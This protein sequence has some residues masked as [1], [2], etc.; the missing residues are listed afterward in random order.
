M[1][2]SE[3]HFQYYNNFKK[4]PEFQ[5]PIADTMSLIGACFMLT[6]ER[7][8]KLNICDKD[9]GSWGSQ[10]IEV[11]VKS[12]T[13]GGKVMVNKNTWFAHCFRTQKGFGFPYPQSNTQVQ[14]AKQKA[15]ELFF[16]NKWEGQIYPLSYMVNK[17][18]PLPGW[19]EK[20]LEQ[21]HT[22]ELKTERSGIYSIT[23]KSNG[24]IYI[25][26]SINISNRIFEHLRK[27]R[28]K[29]HNNTH[30]QNNYDKYGETDLVF[31]IVRFCSNDELLKFEQQYIDEFKEKVGWDNMFNIAPT[32]GSS[33]G[34]ECSD[35]TKQKISESKIGSEPWNKGLT[36]EN[37]ERIRDLAEKKIGINIWENNEHPKGMLGKHH[38]QE[39]KEQISETMSGVTENRER[40]ENGQFV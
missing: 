22:E 13:S 38:S 3:P 6:R 28:Q 26:S 17:F 7:Y 37:D 5:K 35:E 24:R 32:A 14:N 29:S 39:I 16:G 36:K 34:R 33:L 10:G 21:L 4:R 25:G 2:D 15:R 9:F 12:Y 19:S 31:N 8:W 27:L 18:L 20:D 40:N 23:S 1:F 11:A 30:L